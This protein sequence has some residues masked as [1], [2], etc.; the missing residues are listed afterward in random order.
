MLIATWVLAG[1]T[2][3]LA[4]SGPVALAVWLGA[5]RSDRERR[6]REHERELEERIIARAE[7]SVADAKRELVP[8]ETATSIGVFALLGALAI[9]GVRQDQKTQ[10]KNGGKLPPA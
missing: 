7:R 1:F 5:R 6:A 9:W 3:L 4:I 2:G 8:K 10:Q